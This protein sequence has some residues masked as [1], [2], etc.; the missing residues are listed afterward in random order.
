MPPR[1]MTVREAIDKAIAEGSAVVAGG[2]PLATKA[3]CQKLAS[4]PTEPKTKI[5]IVIEICP[6]RVA[7]EANMGGKLK[8]K[9]ARKSAIK[10]A[11][12]SSLPAFRFPLPCVVTL[13]RLG[14]KP[15]DE[16]DNLRRALKA[17]KDVVNKWLGTEDTGRDDRVKWR[18][19]Q[20]PWYEA[21]IRIE[22]ASEATR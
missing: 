14:G 16:D 19:R 21:G 5:R 15:L 20:A 2:M 12:E 7:S 22:V 3:R 13:T 18:F 17:P 4:P 8:D 9:I 1:S 11:V 10:R 6:I